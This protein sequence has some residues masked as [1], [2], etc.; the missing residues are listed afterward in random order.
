MKNLKALLVVLLS[1]TLVA[2]GGNEP[3]I[4]AKKDTFVY[5]FGESYSYNKKDYIKADKDVLSKTKIT[6]NGKSIDTP[7]SS[8]ATEED[9]LK[10][11][12]VGK[13]K[14]VAKYKDEEVKFTVEIKDTTKPEFI[15]FKEKI[16]VDREYDGDLIDQFKAKDLSEVKIKVNTKE[17]DFSKAGEYKAKVIATDSSKNKRT[18][19]FIV[20][21]KEKTK[22][23]REAEENKL[24]EQEQQEQVQQTQQ[25]NQNYDWG[26]Q[27]GS[28]G[29][30]GTGG[31]NGTG[32]GNSS[33]G[34]NPTCEFISWQ[35]VANG[36]I[37]NHDYDY[38]FNWAMVEQLNP[39]GVEGQFG[40]H[41]H[42]SSGTFYMKTFNVIT[43]RDNCGKT[44]YSP[45]FY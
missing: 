38:I 44:G 4:K 9:Y 21:V 10:Y 24:K 40:N 42:V 7:H 23:E 43:V 32:G 19:E 5:E 33:G 26:T 18:K 27:G 39:T 12:A 34:G 2:C 28:T 35:L 37:A 3:K 20:V 29:N 11:Y 22:A 1:M 16:E 30:S 17:V 31:S 25:N 41:K 15:E 14:G 8:F 13:Y 45:S 6:I 36:G